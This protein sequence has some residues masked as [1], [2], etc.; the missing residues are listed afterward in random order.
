MKEVKN[1][2]KLTGKWMKKEP[3]WLETLPWSWHHVLQIEYIYNKEKN[4]GNGQNI[5]IIKRKIK[6]MNCKN[7]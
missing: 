1:K 6:E 7:C 2:G 5:Y 4:K 3:N